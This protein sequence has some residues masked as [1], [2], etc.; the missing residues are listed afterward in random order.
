M[1][2]C[3]KFEWRRRQT[4]AAFLPDSIEETSR[5]LSRN[6]FLPAVSESAVQYPYCLLYVCVCMCVG[7]YI[8]YIC[9]PVRVRATYLCVS[10]GEY[11]IMV[12]IR[13]RLFKKTLNARAYKTRSLNSVYSSPVVTYFAFSNNCSRFFVDTKWEWSDIW[14]IHFLCFISTLDDNINVSGVIV[15]KLRF[16]IT[17]RQIKYK[18]NGTNVNCCLQKNTRWK[19]T[20]R[21][22]NVLAEWYQFYIR[23]Y[24]LIKSIAPV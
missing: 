22:M 2:V 21:T 19:A 11:I 14:K 7:L 13:Q 1:I 12:S 6:N 20:I 4:A 9:K 17:N 24:L 5:N 10:V 18:V 16:G 3:S 15:L 8:W 23:T